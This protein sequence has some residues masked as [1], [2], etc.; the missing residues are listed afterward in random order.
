VASPAPVCPSAQ[1]A[2]LTVTHPLL[3]CPHHPPQGYSDSALVGSWFITYGTIFGTIALAISILTKMTLFGNSAFGYL[4]VL[5][6]VFGMSALSLCWAISTLFS[7]A[8]LAAI[9][10]STL[11]VAGIFP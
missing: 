4:F 10:G 2:S 6:F 9:V 3:P 11:F 7:R 8:K 1:T 5:F